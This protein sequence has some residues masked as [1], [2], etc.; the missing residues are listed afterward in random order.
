MGMFVHPP[1]IPRSTKYLFSLLEGSILVT[2]MLPLV[3]LLSVAESNKAADAPI[4]M[5]SS[6]QSH[7]EG[8]ISAL[9]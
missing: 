1:R 8:V 2:L 4:S 3:G 6:L 9:T 7:Q 5:V